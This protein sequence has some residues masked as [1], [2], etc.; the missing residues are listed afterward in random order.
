M[1]ELHIAALFFSTK[2]GHIVVYYGV[3][4]TSVYL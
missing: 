2:I 1:K 4:N 3:V